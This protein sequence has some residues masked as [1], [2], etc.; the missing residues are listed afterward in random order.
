VT[1]GAV[2][3]NRKRL[4][5]V[6]SV[7][8]SRDSGLLGRRRGAALATLFAT[9]WLVLAG[10]E[11][12]PSH[13]A[14]PPGSTTTIH[15]PGD[16]SEDSPTASTLPASPTPV[17]L[18]EPFAA[19]GLEPAWPSVH[20]SLTV[21]TTTEVAGSPLRG[22]LTVVNGGPETINLSEGA[23]C[24]ID[25]GGELVN[26]SFPLHSLGGTASCVGPIQPVLLNPGV[27]RFPIT[28]AT[29]YQVCGGQPPVT[30]GP[31]CPPPGSPFP[32][33]PAG[34]YQLVLVGDGLVALPE[35]S[36]VTITLTG[37]NPTS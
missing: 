3:G 11:A 19:N 27:T 4:R 24:G 1:P 14:A 5:Y 7:R 12:T 18:G 36:P 2:S 32:P 26:Q 31:P 23:S 22:T 33:L 25:F 16:A 13:N 35:P 10:C 6:E 30:A 8:G 9:S 20:D 28:V 34:T 37:A 15:H 21:D 17:P 29:T